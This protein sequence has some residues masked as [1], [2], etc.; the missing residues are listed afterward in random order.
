MGYYRCSYC[1]NLHLSGEKCPK[2]PKYQKKTTSPKFYRTKEWVKLREVIKNKFHFVDIW[3]LGKANIVKQ[4]PVGIVHHIE[5]YQLDKD[6]ALEAKNLIYCSVESHNEIHHYY[7]T[8]RK[9]EALEIINKGL[10]RFRQ[11]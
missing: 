11:L 9:D 1:H 6:L 4:V 3:L 5:E 8:F 7:D 2:R 10:E